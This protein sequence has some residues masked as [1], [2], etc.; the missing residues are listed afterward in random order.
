MKTKQS[1]IFFLA[2]LSAL[3]IL[4]PGDAAPQNMGDK[5]KDKESI[6]G[7]TE[8]DGMITLRLNLD[9]ASLEERGQLKELRYFRKDNAIR[10]ND[11]LLIED[12]APACGIPEGYDVAEK[13]YLEKLHKGVIVRKDFILDDPRACSG[14]LL[15]LGM[16][17]K[18]NTHPLHISVN[19]NTFLRLPTRQAFPFAKQ[20]IDLG[21]TRWFIIEMPV[22]A[23]KKGAN[24]ILLWSESEEPSWE[25]NIAAEEEFKRGSLTRT[26]HP[27]RSAKS[28]DNGKTWNY[29]KLGWKNKID[30]E[31]SI[32]LSLDR[33][34]PEG[35]YISPVIDMAEDWQKVSIKE[36]LTLKDVFVRWNIDV[37]EGSRMKI[38]ARL[39]ESPILKAQ[40]WTDYEEVIA[41]N[42]S[43]LW[44]NPAGRYLQFKVI[45]T[46]ENPLVTPSLKGISIKTKFEKIPVKTNVMA[47]L[48]E[49]RNGRVIR[50]SYE[51]TDEDYLNKKLQDFRKKFELDKVV[52]G[53]Q[54]E[55]EI[56]MRLLRWA[57]EIPVVVKTYSWQYDD[58]AILKRDDK[59]NIIL[60][61]D[62]PQ[63]RRDKICIHSNLVLLGA[64]LSFGL[65][66]KFVNINSENMSGHEVMEVWSNEFNKWIHLDATEDFYYYDPDTG[67][68]LNLIELNSRLAELLPRPETWQYPFKV[69]FPDI[70]FASHARIARRE[71]NNRFSIRDVHE[72]QILFTTMGHLR[73]TLRNDFMSNPLPTPVLQGYA[74]WGWN[75]F[76][77]FYS[78]TFPRRREYQCQ[79]ER[80]Q[81]FNRTLNQSE[82]T[83]SET[84][85][86]VILRVDID[87]ETPCFQTFLIRIDEG[88]W[89]E[90]RSSSFE[91]QLHEGLNRLRVRVRNTAGVL[92]PESYASV[93]MNN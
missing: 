3:Q 53:A 88:E 82:F 28:A 15:F 4:L 9:A 72:E 6:A 37:P 46:A 55:F 21:W 12:D 62:Y 49:L 51:L 59:G 79:T 52:A 25:I 24:E 76:L 34:V 11:M 18:D 64:C 83:L 33:S 70:S 43:K 30:G 2:C 87:T 91:W 81:D 90:N 19:G 44:K 26:H 45:M 5:L 13:A 75:G 93:V 85:Q 1:I 56:I 16:E 60:Q 65:P 61:K 57:Y 54:T 80:W 17:Y 23:L 86:P 48:V 58:I 84:N 67:I 50:P 42:F 38:L 31:Y 47:R 35:I 36:L 20:Y 29:D 22:G 7:K 27:N 32:R 92:G 78:Q 74:M 41:G 69:E 8:P 77:N 89:K 68:P 66:A 40:S 73:T 14:Y 63:R 10:L 71:G 39:G